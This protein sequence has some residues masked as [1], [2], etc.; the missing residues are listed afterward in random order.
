M[1]DDTN[2]TKWAVLFA[3]FPAE[4]PLAADLAQLRTKHGVDHLRLE[5]EVWLNAIIIICLFS[6]LLIQ[7]PMTYPR[8]PPFIR[9][10]SPRFMFHTGHVTIGGYGPIFI[11]NDSLNTHFYRS[12]CIETL[13][14]TGTPTGWQP[15]MSIWSILVQCK[16][17]MVDGNARIDFRNLQRPYTLQEAKSAFTRVAG[18]HG[19]IEKP[20]IYLI[21]IHV[22]LPVYLM[23]K[24][25][26]LPPVYTYPITHWSVILGGTR[27]F[28]C[29]CFTYYVISRFLVVSTRYPA[30]C[31]S[32]RE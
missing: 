7:F 22:L 19:W 8:D 6:S 4:T 28:K 24:Q 26:L 13:V 30:V 20:G 1:E 17:L 3:N 5:I 10:I 9:V 31:K 18:Q 2:A 23:K 14:N 25:V 11:F 29:F 16:Q 15:S 27:Y 32:A 12:L 21:F